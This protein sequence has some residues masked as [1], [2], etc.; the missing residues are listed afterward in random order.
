MLSHEKARPSEAR[1]QHLN[2]GHDD[3]IL[4]G[5]N[6][7]QYSVISNKKRQLYTHILVEI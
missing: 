2:Q 3:L 4:D 7:V 6:N 1:F 5:I